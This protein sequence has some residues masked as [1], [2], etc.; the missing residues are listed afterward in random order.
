MSGRRPSIAELACVAKVTYPTRKAAQAG[1]RH[2]N[3]ITDWN[4]RDRECLVA[5]RCMVCGLYHVGHSDVKLLRAN[6]VPYKR[7]K[8]KLEDIDDA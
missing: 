8:P 2:S 4:G 3:R 5:Y 6:A 7:E 1:V